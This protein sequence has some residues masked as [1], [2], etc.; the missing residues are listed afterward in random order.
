MRRLNHEQEKLL[1]VAALCQ[2]AIQSQRD[3]E[4]REGFGVDDYTEGRIVG[5]ANLAR[6]I[7]RTLSGNH[8]DASWDGTGPRRTAG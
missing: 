8:T 3:R 7:L 5:A 2:N 1:R 6:A 4:R